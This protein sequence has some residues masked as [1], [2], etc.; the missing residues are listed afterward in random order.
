MRE[1]LGVYRADPEL[2]GAREV[3]LPGVLAHGG[4]AVEVEGR[5]HERAAWLEVDST[6]DGSGQSQSLQVEADWYDPGLQLPNPKIAKVLPEEQDSGVARWSLLAPLQVPRDS[7]VL[8]DDK[9]LE[10]LLEM[11]ARGA[12]N[13]KDLRALLKALGTDDSEA[14]RRLPSAIAEV[15]LLTLPDAL[16]PRGASS[17]F[18]LS[19]AFVPPVLVPAMRLLLSL[20]PQLLAVWTGL[21]DVKLRAT[22]RDQPEVPPLLGEWRE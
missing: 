17:V 5:S 20:L 13:V 7:P 9:R 15:E 12:P 10:E 2:P 4:Y 6:P 11:H 8:G 18:E 1:V 3:V 14:F 22:F 21:P 16:S 19:I